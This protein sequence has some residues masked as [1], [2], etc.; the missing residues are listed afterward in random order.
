MVD[1][2]KFYERKNYLFDH[3][4][5][6]SSVED[7]VTIAHNYNSITKPCEDNLYEEKMHLSTPRLSSALH[8]YQTVTPARNDDDGTTRQYGCISK[9]LTSKV[10]K[11][12]H[13]SMLLM[14]DLSNLQPLQ[15]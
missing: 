10:L 15:R 5:H 6:D 4:S 1:K 13:Q 9:N 3:M 11:S 14:N 8:K 12:G 2:D 7:A